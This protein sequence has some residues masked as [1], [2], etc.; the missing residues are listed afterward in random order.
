MVVLTR[1]TPHRRRIAS[2]HHRKTHPSTHPWPRTGAGTASKSPLSYVPRSFSLCPLPA[3]SLLF[4]PAD[5]NPKL[6]SSRKCLLLWPPLADDFFAP[7]TNKFGAE[8]R[9]PHLAH[10]R[11]W[12]WSHFHLTWSSFSASKLIIDI[13]IDIFKGS[14]MRTA[15]THESRKAD[16]IDLCSAHRD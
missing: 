13:I 6:S 15:R 16:I 10:A 11:R 2:I 8:S 1:S 9:R 12:C 14:E 3:A 5:S 7:L 4:G